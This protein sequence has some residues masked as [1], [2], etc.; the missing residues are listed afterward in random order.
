V[1]ATLLPALVSVAEKQQRRRTIRTA[2]VAA[3]AVA[4]IAGG[5]AVVV[6]SLGEDEAPPA[7]SPSVT[8]AT[9][10]PPQQMAAL[11]EGQSD[12]WVSLTPEGMGTRI[13]LTCTYRS[14]YSGNHAYRYRLVVYSTDGRVETPAVFKARSGEERHATG[15]TSIPPDEI[16][17]VVVENSYGPILLLNPDRTP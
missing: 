6:A 2:L 13:D 9:T 14:S 8:V 3:A 1:P 5:T 15:T 12:G 7:S 16:E 4:V 11:G 10:A 17:K